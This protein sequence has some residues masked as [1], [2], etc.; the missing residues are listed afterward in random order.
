MSLLESLYLIGLAGVFV[1]VPSGPGYAGTLDAA[2]LFGAGAIG[3]SPELSLSFLLVARF[4]VFV[5]ITIAGLALMV[6]TYGWDSFGLRGNGEHTP[7]PAPS[8]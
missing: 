6:T 7:T 4:V 2:L 1:L 8:A 5:P 3:A